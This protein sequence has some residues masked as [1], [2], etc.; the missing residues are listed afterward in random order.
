M[1]QYNIF[2]NQSFIYPCVTIYKYV[3]Y[4]IRLMIPKLF[5]VFKNNKENIY[6]L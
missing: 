5:V 4:I 1:L 3:S 2:E 6:N